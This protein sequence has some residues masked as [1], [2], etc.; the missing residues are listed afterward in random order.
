VEAVDQKMTAR[1]PGYATQYSGKAWSLGCDV[2][3]P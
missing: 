1:P 2:G 3:D